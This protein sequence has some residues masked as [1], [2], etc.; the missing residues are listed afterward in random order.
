[1]KMD[2]IQ[3][4]RCFLATAGCNLQFW[5]GIGTTVHHEGFRPIA[6]INSLRENEA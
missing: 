2:S 4:P 1:M 5:G 3:Q 6:K